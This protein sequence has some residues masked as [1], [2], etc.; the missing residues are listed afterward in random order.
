MGEEREEREEVIRRNPRIRKESHPHHSHS[1]HTNTVR[2]HLLSPPES[3]VVVPYSLVHIAVCVCPDAD[4]LFLVV[5][6]H[7][8]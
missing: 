7:T 8:L 1:S 6:P 2:T 5:R 4:A 3:L